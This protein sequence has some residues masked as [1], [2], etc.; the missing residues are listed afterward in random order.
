MISVVH[1][2]I[3]EGRRIAIPAELC[4]QFGLEPGDPVVL[5]ASGDGIVL[6]P[7]ETVIQEVRAFF[8]DTGPADGLMSDEL[9][10]ERREEAKRE[11]NG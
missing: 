5:E 3:G 6:R 11:T 2:K 4:H 9:I 10:R 1:T 7:L 8:A